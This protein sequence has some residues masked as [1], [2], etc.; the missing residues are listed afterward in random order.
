MH[1]YRFE[2]HGVMIMIRRVPRTTYMQTHR[3]LHSLLID[4]WFFTNIAR[5]IKLRGLIKNA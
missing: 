2:I 3:I 4:M 1:Y 5:R